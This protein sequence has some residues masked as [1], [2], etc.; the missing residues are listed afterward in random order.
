MDFVK[1]CCKIFLDKDASA[2]KFFTYKFMGP[3]HILLIAILIIGG[4]FLIRTYVKSTTERR[5]KIRRN[6]SIILITCEFIAYGLWCV[7]KLIK[8]QKIGAWD[9]PCSLC[10]YTTV[11]CIID[12]LKPIYILRSYMLHLG[13]WG[14]LAAYLF[15]DSSTTPMFNIFLLE[16]FFYHFIIIIYPLMLFFSKEFRPDYGDLPNMFLFLFN[17]AWPL[18]IF[19]RITMTN[20]MVLRIPING[21]PLN[22]FH[23]WCGNPGY[24]LCIAA[25]LLL[26]WLVMYTPKMIFYLYR[27]RK[28]R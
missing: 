9:C 17:M 27:K 28:R 12:G 25:C 2:S 22:H 14:A 11:F 8:G 16:F 6:I 4:F 20:H 24:L 19:D 10:F 5:N 23:R 1:N 18:Y 13:M 3:W 7:E 26:I 21:F 15:C